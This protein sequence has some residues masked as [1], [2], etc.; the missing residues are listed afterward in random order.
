MYKLHD[1]CHLIQQDVDELDAAAY[2]DVERKTSFGNALMH[3]RRQR[4]KHR[5]SNQKI[6]SSMTDLEEEDDL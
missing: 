2:A 3:R 6:Y 4:S 5:R 1:K